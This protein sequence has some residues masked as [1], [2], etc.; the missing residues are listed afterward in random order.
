LFHSHNAPP[1][2]T[3]LDELDWIEV[4]W[5]GLEWRRKLGA[6]STKLSSGPLCYA[7]VNIETEKPKKKRGQQ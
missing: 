3:D 7:I 6:S 2:K 4:D 5:S 1:K